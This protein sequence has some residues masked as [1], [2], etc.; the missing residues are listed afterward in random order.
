MNHSDWFF[1][2]INI[3]IYL[4]LSY[5][6]LF[7]MKSHSPFLLCYPGPGVAEL[8]LFFIF[9][10]LWFLCHHVG[11]SR[12]LRHTVFGLSAR[13]YV[14][15]NIRLFNFQIVS[16]PTALKIPI[17]IQLVKW[18]GLSGMTGYDFWW[19]SHERISAK[20]GNTSWFPPLEM[21]GAILDS[22][23]LPN[24]WCYMNAVNT[25]NVQLLAQNRLM[26]VCCWCDAGFPQKLAT[27][28]APLTAIENN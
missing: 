21:N 1:P 9:C 4:F 13:P 11:D 8:E 18:A 15:T 20:S 17:H 7:T 14:C 24:N 16:P 26:K 10:C 28:P 22:L 27:N 6:W 5:F 12:S 2:L 19:W 23:Q 3:F 25:R